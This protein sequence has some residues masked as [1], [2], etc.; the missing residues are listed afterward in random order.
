M[1]P[2]LEQRL[3]EAGETV[4]SPSARS[5]MEA[6]E[7]TL[8]VMLHRRRRRLRATAAVVVLAATTVVGI[9]AGL[10]IAPSGGASSPSVAGLGFLPAKGWTIVQSAPGPA[11]LVG[12]LARN[13]GSSVWSRTSGRLFH[14]HVGNWLCASRAPHE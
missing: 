10:W 1:S 12:A 3:R 9:G 7:R 14:T 13:S 2:D 6:R 5:T 8:S 11:A 4:P